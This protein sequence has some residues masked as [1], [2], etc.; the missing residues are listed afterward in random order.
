MCNFQIILHQEFIFTQ[1]R[2]NSVKRTLFFD[3]RSR[4]S[5]SQYLTVRSSEEFR[6]PS[7]VRKFPRKEPADHRLMLWRFRFSAE[8]RGGEAAAR[9]LIDGYGQVSS[10]RI[11]AALSAWRPSRWKHMDAGDLLGRMRVGCR[12]R[13]A[14]GWSFG[15]SLRGHEAA[16]RVV[17][18]ASGGLRGCFQRA[19]TSMTIMRPPQQEHGGRK[20]SGSP[21]A[22]SS[23][24]A[25]TCR[26]RS[27]L[28]GR[29][30][31]QALI[32]TNAFNLSH[33]RPPAQRVRSSAPLQ[34]STST[35]LTSPVAAKPP[36][37]PTMM[38]L[39]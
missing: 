26:S 25:S 38:R 33:R 2:R 18:V 19:K 32:P 9:K 20:S 29:R 23:T 27:A 28:A 3:V 34:P 21:G 17:A 6:T 39:L 5:A 13:E 30:S 24:G 31:I 10:L 35:R 8:A 7:G 11:R 12:R 14:C 4:P 16:S 1:P 37:R 22:V 15:H 36:S